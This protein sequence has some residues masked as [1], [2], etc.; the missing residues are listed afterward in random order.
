MQSIFAK[1]VA[2]L[3]YRVLSDIFMCKFRDKNACVSGAFSAILNA[4][5][6]QSAPTVCEE[7]YENMEYCNSV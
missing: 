7:D 5:V 3:R 6:G 2:H 4:K 1:D